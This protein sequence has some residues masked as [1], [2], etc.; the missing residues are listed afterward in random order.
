MKS[1]GLGKALATGLTVDLLSAVVLRGLALAT[2]VV[3][4][5]TL[6]PASYGAVSLALAV[7]GVSDMLTNPALGVAVLRQQELDDRTIDVAWT[8]SLLRSLALG[9]ALFLAAPLLARIWKGDAET[10]SY[11]ELLSL[12]PVTGALGNMH[13]VRLQRALRFGRAMLLDNLRLLATSLV[14]LGLLLATKRAGSLVL[15]IVVGNLVYVVIS[16]A[17][18][19]PLPRL[20]FSASTARELSRV[21]RWLMVHSVFVYLCVTIDNLYVGR[22][23]GLAALGAYALAWRIVNT[24]MTL[25]TRAIAK[26]LVP[27]YQKLGSDLVQLRR[28]VLS[29]LFPSAAVG[30]LASG[31]VFLCAQDIFLVLGGKGSFP[32]AATVAA[33]LTPYVYTRILNN[34]LSPL[35]QGVGSPRTLAMLSATNLTLLLPTIPLGAMLFGATGV[36][37]A[38]SAV[39]VLVTTL[40]VSLVR[41]RFG[42]PLL[43]QLKAILLPLLLVTPAA[44]VGHYG[45]QS[46]AH[47]GVRLGVAALVTSVLFAAAWEGARLL[48]RDLPSLVRPI[49]ALVQRQRV[50]KDSAGA[51]G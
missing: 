6:A 17:V 28:A 27:A 50:A 39:S 16:W 9:L 45:S 7:Y 3:V 20:A 43:A 51:S 15:G 18:I 32:G 10:A 40:L 38:V 4:A 24:F 49:L 37:L 31:L 29:A 1:G 13:A 21:S 41:A 11:L 22:T 14:S 25:L 19:R 47:A 23:L 8:L 46:A 2:T 44:L 36:A 26:M 42:I 48:V 34:V 5:R 30:A 33:A 12:A 35:Y